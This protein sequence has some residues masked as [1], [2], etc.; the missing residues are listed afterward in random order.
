MVEHIFLG[1]G[2]ALLIF[3]FQQRNTFELKAQQ[4]KAAH[5]FYKELTEKTNRE[6]HNYWRENNRLR[7][8]NNAYRREFTK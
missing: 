7:A 1:I 8:L 4:E 6:A 5:H 2:W 3:C